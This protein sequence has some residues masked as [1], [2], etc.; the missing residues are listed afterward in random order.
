MHAQNSISMFVLA[1]YHESNCYIRNQSSSNLIDPVPLKKKK[2]HVAGRIDI[3][4]FTVTQPVHKYV[5]DGFSTQKLNE[6]A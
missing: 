2:N 6:S 5:K 1:A 3:L 4:G